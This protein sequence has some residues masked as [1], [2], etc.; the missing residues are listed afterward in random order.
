[1][2]SRTP[3]TIIDMCSKTGMSDLFIFMALNAKK[4]GFNVTYLDPETVE[5]TEEGALVLHGRE[6]YD[7][8]HQSNLH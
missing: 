8:K 7:E 3:V 6:E 2:P 4:K 1:M 5:Y